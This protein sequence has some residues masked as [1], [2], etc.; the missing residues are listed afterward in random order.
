MS[1][2]VVKRRTMKKSNAPKVKKPPS[3]DEI[4]GNEAEGPDNLTLVVQKSRVKKLTARQILAAED[5]SIMGMVG[6]LSVFAQ[7]D[8]E[9][10]DPEEA[11]EIILDW[12]VE[13]IADVFGT[14]MGGIN[15]VAAPN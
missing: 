7:E 10:M 15:E 6:V 11:Y 4:E 14:V 5:G 9:Y 12:D 8:G 3:L 13:T 2:R 1:K